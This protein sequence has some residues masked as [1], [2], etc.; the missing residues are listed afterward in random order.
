MSEATELTKN[1]Q[2]LIN[3]LEE[4]TK[5][6]SGGLPSYVAT[7]SENVGSAIE[8][9][10]ELSKRYGNTP[11]SLHDLRKAG[12]FKNIMCSSSILGSALGMFPSTIEFNDALTSDIKNS[13]IDDTARVG[14]KVVVG[15]GIGAILLPYA[16]GAATVGV[17]LPW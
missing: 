1:E 9:N 17:A 11:I 6:T 10:N 7:I 8:L 13:R 14:L 5:N 12:N 15:I 16:A 2:S 3:K 4:E